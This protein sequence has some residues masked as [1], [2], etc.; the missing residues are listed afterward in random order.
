M[1]LDVNDTFFK[2]IIFSEERPTYGVTGYGG[3]LGYDAAAN[4][5]S[6]GTYHETGEYRA[7]N[8]LRQNGYIGIGTTNPSSRLTNL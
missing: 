2:R 5:I 1:V 8:I 7:L 6:L 4:T 3:Y